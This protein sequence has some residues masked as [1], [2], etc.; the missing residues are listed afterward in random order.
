MHTHTHLTRLPVRWMFGMERTAW[1]PKARMTKSRSPK[2]LQL[3]YS[4]VIW[5]SQPSL[6]VRFLFLFLSLSKPIWPQSIA[7]QGL[8]MMWHQRGTL[9][10]AEIAWILPTER[11]KTSRN[12]REWKLNIHALNWRN[13]NA[14][15]VQKTEQKVCASLSTNQLPATF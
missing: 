5:F 9:I 15:I 8:V 14:Y 12:V 11:T 2:G 6:A 10:L 7:G 4:Y 3:I 13:Q 1:V